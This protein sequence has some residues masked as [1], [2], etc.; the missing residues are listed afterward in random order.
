M[1]VMTLFRERIELDKVQNIDHSFA[2][3]M[4]ID[5]QPGV[6]RAFMMCEHQFCM[7][8]L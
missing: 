3:L 7:S 5:V 8:F 1:I 4:V 6:L 2:C